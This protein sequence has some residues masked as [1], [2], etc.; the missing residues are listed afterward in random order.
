[1]RGSTAPVV[2]EED[3]KEGKRLPQRIAPMRRCSFRRAGIVP[4]APVYVHREKSRVSRFRK[5]RVPFDLL[6][7]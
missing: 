4:D 1:M 7:K 3:A 2:G 6:K 5:K